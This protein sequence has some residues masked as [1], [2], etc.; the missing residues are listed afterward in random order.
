MKRAGKRWLGRG[1][2]ILLYA[3]LALLL[4]LG[5]L[6]SA[7]DSR[8]LLGAYPSPGGAQL[9]EVYLYNPGALCPWC[10][11]D[12][13][14]GRGVLGKRRIYFAW[15]EECAEVRWLDAETI[16]INENEINIFHDF[17]RRENDGWAA[18]P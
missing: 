18:Q 13:V 14:K 5:I 12:Y 16:V 8:E 7:G 2:G 1:I 6:L 15:R 9:V 10:I 4:L 3:V 17:I 11:E